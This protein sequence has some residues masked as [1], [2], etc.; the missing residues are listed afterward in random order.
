MLDRYNIITGAD[1]ATALAKADAY[2]STQPAERNVRSY[3][4]P[5]RSSRASGEAVR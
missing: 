5:R 2:R 1:T 3:R 4:P